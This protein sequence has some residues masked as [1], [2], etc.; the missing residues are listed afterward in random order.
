MIIGI[1]ARALASGPRHGVGEYAERIIAGMIQKGP[2]HEFKIFFSSFRRRFPSYSWL[3][4]PNVRAYHFRWPNNAL[5]M[6]NRFF[7]WPKIDVMM[8]GVDVFFSPHLFLASLSSSCRRVSVI[9]DLAFERFPELFTLRQRLWHGMM[10]A[11][12]QARLSNRLIAVSYSTKSDLVSR[13]HIDPVNIS[14]IYSGTTLQRPPEK[15][16]EDFKAVHAL[17]ERFVFS[18]GTL[19]PRKN[20]TGLIRAFNLLK[21]KPGFEDLKLLIGGSTGWHAGRMRQVFE[22]SPYRNDIVIIGHVPDNE[23]SFYYSLS[24]MFVYPS[25]FEGFG[26]PVLEAMACGTPVITSHNSSLPEVVNGT[27]ILVDP[28][29]ISDIAESMESLLSDTLLRQEMVVRGY[30]QAG[31][32]SWERTITETLVVITRP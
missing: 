6:L 7:G 9:H 28:Y 14:V 8:G 2:E 13:Y 19:E 23:R 10:N 5:F 24:S 12:Q 32:F 26:F 16:L 29:N 21:S 4:A 27:A 3:D 17:P 18:L 31:E 25:F 20:I 15:E 22:S 30:R 11:S 1:D